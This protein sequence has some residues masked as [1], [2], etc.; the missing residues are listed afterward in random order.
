MYSNYQFSVQ[1][2]IDCYTE[3]NIFLYRNVFECICE[4]K[5]LYRLSI[6]F[7]IVMTNYANYTD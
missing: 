6:V 5:N 2:L 4:L 7:S 1:K 3:I